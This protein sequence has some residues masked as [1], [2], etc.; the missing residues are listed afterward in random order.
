GSIASILYA[1][2][3]DKAVSKEKIDIF[4]DKAVATIDDFRSGEFVR[5]KRIK[6]GGGAQDKGHAAEVSAFVAAA[7]GQSPSP[8]NLESLA[9][10]TLT[11]FG[12]NESVR[13]GKAVAID[14]GRILG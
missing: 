14:A 8:F 13:T 2:S 4:C 9:A 1:A 3:G 10:T 6:L 11:T 7:R 12:I 5:G